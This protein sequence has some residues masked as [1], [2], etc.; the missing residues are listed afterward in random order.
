MHKVTK[1]EDMCVEFDMNTKEAV[2]MIKS[3]EDENKIKGILDEWGK[4]ILI[5][6]Q[7]LKD[8]VEMIKQK[9]WVSK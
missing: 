3:L 9:G 4:Y 8:L 1:I 7:E 2:Q 6:P 5:T